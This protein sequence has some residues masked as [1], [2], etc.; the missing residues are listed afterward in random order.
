MKVL[1][2]SATGCMGSGL[3][4][5][6]K[7]DTNHQLYTFTRNLDSDSAKPLK[8][9]STKVFEGDFG[10]KGSLEEAFSE[11]FD[12]VFFTIFPDLT[13][14]SGDLDQAENI[15]DAAKRHGVKQLLYG[16]VARTGTQENFDKVL[17]TLEDSN[18]LKGYWVK[19][20]AIEDMVRKSGLAY[21]IV[22]PPNFIQNLA[23]P[24]YVAMMYPDLP[25]DYIYKNAVDPD[26]AQWWVDGS[27][28][29]KF[30][31]AAVRD[32]ERFRNKEITIGTELLTDRQIVEKLRMATG[33]DVKLYD[34]PADEW[35]ASKTHFIHGPRHKSSEMGHDPDGGNGAKEY[36]VQPTL[37]SE[38]L[39]DPKNKEGTWLA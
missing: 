18:F 26:V 7:D 20:W 13:G 2:L 11:G 37:I 3:V 9:A 22:K 33:K 32:P 16:S 30:A 17:S 10:N 24:N 36:G 38:W 4:K 14:G 39:E 35:E 23:W 5:A 19:K 12:A 27:D 28:V 6:L 1:A 29:G 8:E 34:W 25:K 31:A 15:V 21:T